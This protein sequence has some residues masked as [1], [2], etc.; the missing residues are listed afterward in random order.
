MI[1]T[2]P[3]PQPIRTDQNNPRPMY[4]I[5]GNYLTRDDL[6]A[7]AGQPKAIGAM[8]D[9]A[10]AAWPKAEPQIQKAAAIVQRP[11]SPV[12]ERHTD[13]NNPGDWWRVDDGGYKAHSCSIERNYCNCA[14]YAP[15][16]PKA[17]RLCPH[18]IAAMFQRRILQHNA[19]RLI[20]LIQRITEAAAENRDI[21]GRLT[22]P[23]L[24]EIRIVIMYDLIFRDAGENDKAITRIGATGINPM[25]IGSNEKIA[26]NNAGLAAAARATGYTIG[27]PMIAGAVSMKIVLTVADHQNLPRRSDVLDY[28]RTYLKIRDER[29]ARRDRIGAMMDEAIEAAAAEEDARRRMDAAA[30]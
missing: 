12:I 23:R 24:E 30:D 26:I 17:G 13:S 18:R 3:L 2:T 6:A 28:D 16:D 10:I 27:D 8:M 14:G 9:A 19:Q 15:E 21:Q 22:L 25:P 1:R 20:A 7:A 11:R 29:N 4:G 5:P